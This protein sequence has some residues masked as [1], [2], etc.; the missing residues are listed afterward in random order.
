MMDN[1]KHKH[2]SQALYNLVNFT[3]VEEFVQED[4]FETIVL[5]EVL[6][7]SLNYGYQGHQWRVLDKVNGQRVDTMRQL[8]EICTPFV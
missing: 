5:I 6:A 7:D 2:R 4:G 3:H 8:C 1:K